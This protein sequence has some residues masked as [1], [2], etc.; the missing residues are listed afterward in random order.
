LGAAGGLVKTTPESAQTHLA[1]AESMVYDVLQELDI[2]IQEMHPVVL[3]ERGLVLALRD[4]VFEWAHQNEVEIDFK[5]EGERALPLMVEQILYR[6]AQE[7]LA[8]VA[9]HSQARTVDILLEFRTGI[10]HLAICDDGCGFDPK[11]TQLGMG[12]R[13]MRERSEMFNGSLHIES[14]PGD[15]MRIIAEIPV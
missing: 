13:S 7:A 8:N 1:E 11:T 3:K 9:R 5:V 10:T 4:Y 14:N 2:L 15:G 12:L 6:I